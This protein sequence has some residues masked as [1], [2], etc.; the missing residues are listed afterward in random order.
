MD[1]SNV[2][3]EVWSNVEVFMEVNF[4]NVELLLPRVG[5]LHDVVPH[6]HVVDLQP[7]PAH[8]IHRLLITIKAENLTTLITI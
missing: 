2:I 8:I 1:N 6:P 5:H 4:V 3:V 7:L